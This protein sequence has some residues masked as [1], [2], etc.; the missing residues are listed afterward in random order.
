MLKGLNMK[1][2]L[3][4]KTR[5]MIPFVYIEGP[6]E[7]FQYFS[8]YRQAGINLR[9]KDDKFIISARARN[10]IMEIID[11]FFPTVSDKEKDYDSIDF[12]VDEWFQYDTEITTIPEELSPKER[13]AV[14]NF[15]K[16]WWNLDCPELHYCN[17]EIINGTIYI[18]H[19]ECMWRH[20]WNAPVVSGWNERLKELFVDVFNRQKTYTGEFIEEYVERER[21]Q[22]E[23]EMKK[24]QNI[25]EKAQFIVEQPEVQYACSQVPEENYCGWALIKP[26]RKEM[27]ICL[28]QKY[29][30]ETLD[31]QYPKA[32]MSLDCSEGQA[33]IIA[34]QIE[35]FTG[36]KMVIV[37]RAD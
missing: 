9:F 5:G 19:D 8:S 12:Q 23:E 13:E 24:L 20:Y 36:E 22:P 30:R 32:T 33:K 34:K 14:I 3:T 31:I 21:P 18:G 29:G 15:T 37:T 26:L 6:R 28:W 1:N 25:V 11:K 35:E 27:R 17:A 10:N 2:K 4:L 16:Y 7:G